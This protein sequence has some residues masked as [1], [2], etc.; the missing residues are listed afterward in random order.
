MSK[1]KKVFVT[2]AGLGLFVLLG[3]I[4]FSEKGLSDL[5]RLKAERDILLENKNAF[6]EENRILYRKI[7]R[8]KDDPRFIESV[9]RD[10]LGM[11][12]KDEIICKFK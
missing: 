9:A 6:D 10:E 8:L 5:N 2:F 3:V 4:I 7:K 12:G 1:I 11:I